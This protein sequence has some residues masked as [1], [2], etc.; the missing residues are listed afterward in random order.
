M[1]EDRAEKRIERELTGEPVQV[2][3][4]TLRPVARLHARRGMSQGASQDWA[5]A[6]ARLEPTALIVESPD[7]AAEPIVIADPADRIAQRLVRVGLL[8]AA[9]SAGIVLALEAGALIASGRITN[10]RRHE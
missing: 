7:G 5:W 3:T 8:V 10:L 6:H 9:V 4:F 1:T 2:G